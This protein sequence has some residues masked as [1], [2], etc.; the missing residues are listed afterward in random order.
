MV[1][2][3]KKRFLIQEKEKITRLAISREWLGRGKCWEIAKKVIFTKALQ[4]DQ[5]TDGQMDQRTHPLIELVAR[6]QKQRA[7]ERA[8]VSIRER[9]RGAHARARTHI[10]RKI[11]QCAS[12]IFLIFG[13]FLAHLGR[14]WGPGWT[15][16]VFYWH[17]PMM[18]GMF[19]TLKVEAVVLGGQP[20]PNVGCRWPISSWKWWF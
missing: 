3:W 20:P 12:C 10:Q 6:D 19:S 15:R 4:W 9:E 16:C 1:V 17:F 18:L 7:R 2:L 11:Y 8:R 13:P 14:R 5:W